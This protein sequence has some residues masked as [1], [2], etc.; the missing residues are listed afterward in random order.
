MFNNRL[1]F[2]HVPQAAKQLISKVGIMTQLCSQAAHEIPENLTIGS[3]EPALAYH[4]FSSSPGCFISWA[5]IPVLILFLSQGWSSQISTTSFQ[6]WAIYSRATLASQSKACLSHILCSIAFKK[7]SLAFPNEIFKPVQNQFWIYITVFYT[8]LAEPIFSWLGW[9]S[10][11]TAVKLGVFL[12]EMIQLCRASEFFC[13]GKSF[14][15]AVL[16]ELF[17]RGLAGIALFY[18]VNKSENN[19][20]WLSASLKDE[21]MWKFPSIGTKCCNVGWLPFLRKFLQYCATYRTLVSILFLQTM[22]SFKC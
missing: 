18:P 20:D 22:Q 3:H 4:C 11:D 15:S 10:F 6:S 12:V 21:D 13:L 2:H 5:V 7:Q 14:L 8:A 19:H 17:C 9:G 1:H 16:F